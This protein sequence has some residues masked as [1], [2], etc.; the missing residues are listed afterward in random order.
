MTFLDP[1]NPDWQPEGNQWPP[2]LID[3]A[4]ALHDNQLS[5][6]EPLLRQHLKADPFDVQ[7]IR[8]LAELAGR[9]GRYKDAETLL[10]RALDLAPGFTAARANLA[11]TLHRQNKSVEAITELDRLLRDDPG[12]VGHLNLKGAALASI[13]EYEDAIRQ[14]ETVLAARPE[15]A[16]VWMSYGHALKTVGR[17]ADSVAAYRRSIALAPWLGEAWWSLA[18]LKTVSL[19]ADDVAALRAALAGQ[20][21][22]EDRFHLHFALAKALE[23]IGDPATA[24]QSYIEANRLR[25]T[26]LAYDAADTTQLVDR[27]I[28]LFDRPFFAARAADGCPAPDPIFVVGLPRSGS[29]LVEQILASHPLVEGTQELP[30][31]MHLARRVVTG[32][33]GGATAYP[34]ILADVTP[35]RFRALGEEYLDRTRIHRKTGRPFFIDKMPNNWIHAGFIHLI[36]P[37][38]KIVDARR[39]PLGCCLSNFRQHF[40][41][42]QMFSYSLEDL[43]AYY[44]DYVRLM[45]HLDAVLPGMVHRVIYELMVED[46]EAEVRRLLAYCGLDF[47]PACLRFYETE[48]A[49]RT[50]S[51]EQ[52][53]QPIFRSGVENWPVF[54]P[55]LGPL[56]AALGPA[57]ANW[58]GALP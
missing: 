31:I 28:A 16:K 6:A 21:G 30:D 51:S 42:G 23:D 55:W 52:V 48:R 34:D 10:R 33:P 4:L 15:Q 35:G 3:A 53:R 12:Q 24:F 27:G 50:A 45:A 22:D 14:F 7:A 47:D 40:A 54:E 29:T 37:N 36:L 46:T 32:E 25:R 26:L 57:L 18:N 41:R 20:V 9:L 11:V 1:T 13:G 56:K 2:H 43:G 5:V 8:M 49:V 19:D 44:A 39:H 17:Q 38:A 58:D